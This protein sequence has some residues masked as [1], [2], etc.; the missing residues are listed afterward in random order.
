MVLSDLLT[1][2]PNLTTQLSLTVLQAIFW[3][4]FIKTSSKK[5]FEP[6]VASMPWK[7]Q[8]T[9]LNRKTFKASFFIDFDSQGA[10]EFACLFLAVLLQHAVGGG[11]CC[12]SL[13]WHP[14]VHPGRKQTAVSVSVRQQ[15]GSPAPEVTSC[16]AATAVVEMSTATRESV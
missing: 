1:A 8:W 14:R 13:A 2:A 16:A 9:E 5:I 6:L 11:L 4:F 7:D 3:Y 15:T 10:F 12:S